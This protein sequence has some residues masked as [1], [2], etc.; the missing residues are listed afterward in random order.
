VRWNIGVRTPKRRIPC[1]RTLLGS[2]A[3]SHRRRRWNAGADARGASADGDEAA[4][5]RAS[6]ISEGIVA[7]VIES[8]RKDGVLTVRVRFRNT[9]DK[10][11]KFLLVHAGRYED[12]Y[13][14]AGSTKYHDHS[15]FTR[16]TTRA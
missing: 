8:N 12:N 13:I 14:S 9:S 4:R 15:A 7:E 2:V 1:T 3:A 6:W 10:R 5:A 11:H 16:R